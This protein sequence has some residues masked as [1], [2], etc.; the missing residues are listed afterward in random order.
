VL[1]DHSDGDVSHLCHNHQCHEPTHLVL[2]S[3]ALN[4]SRKNCVGYVWSP[5]HAEWIEV[6]DHVPRCLTSKVR[7]HQNTMPE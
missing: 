4:H 7:R 5:K 2:E 3:P 6:C 1:V